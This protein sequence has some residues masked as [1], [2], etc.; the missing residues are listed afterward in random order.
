[1]SAISQDIREVSFRSKIWSMA[2]PDGRV[3]KLQKD[4][5]NVGLCADLMWLTL[6]DRRD[7]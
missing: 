1:M 5:F 2:R 4:Q 7:E 6:S 3:K